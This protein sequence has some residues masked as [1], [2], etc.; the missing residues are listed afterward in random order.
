M[1]RVPPRI[2]YRSAVPPPP[3]RRPRPPARPGLPEEVKARVKARD[4]YRCK[5]CGSTRLL[6]VHHI[7]PERFKLYMPVRVELDDPMNLITL[8]KS[9]H[10]A[11]TYLQ[12]KHPEFYLNLVA[13]ELWRRAGPA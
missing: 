7:Y 4:G 3:P 11:C 2:L 5:V 6:E 8:C 9:C 13:P 12:S 10:E 1:W